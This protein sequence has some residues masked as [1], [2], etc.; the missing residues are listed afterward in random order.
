MSTTPTLVLLA[1]ELTLFIAAVAGVALSGAPQ[2]VLR[3]T[4]TGLF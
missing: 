4:A 1:A 3:F 2:L